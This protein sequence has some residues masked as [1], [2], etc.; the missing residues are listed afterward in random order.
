MYKFKIN[1][2]L[3]YTDITEATAWTKL[4]KALSR[5]AVGSPVVH[6]IH[7][8]HL[9][10]HSKWNCTSHVCMGSPV[11]IWFIYGLY[12]VSIWIIYEK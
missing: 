8:R 10:K 2:V 1:N 12:M 4:A 3:N 9:A 11:S 7:Q 5:T 6:E